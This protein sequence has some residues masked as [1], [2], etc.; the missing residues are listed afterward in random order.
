MNKIIYNDFAANAEKNA[1]IP[2]SGSSSYQS[3]NRLLSEDDRDILNFASFEGVGID[4]LDNSLYF[5]EN[6]DNIGYVSSAISSSSNIFPNNYLVIELSD[7]SYSAPGITFYFFK[8][9]CSHLTVT[10]LNG[11]EALSEKKIYVVPEEADA[12][13][14]IKFYYENN[15]DGFNKIKIKFSMTNLKNQFAKLAGIDL[16]RQREITNFH[17]NIQI[18]SEIDPDCAD[19]PGSTCDFIAEIEDFEPSQAQSFFVY[20]GDRL[21]G[22]YYVD[23][24]IPMGKNRYSFECSD[25]IMKLEKSNCEALPQGAYSV[26]SIAEAI[27]TLSNLNIDR[28]GFEDVAV[29]GFLEENTNRYAAAMLSFATGCFLTGFGAKSLTLKKPVNRRNKIISS[30]KILGRAEYKEKTQYSAVVLKIFFD[31]F[32]TVTS[33]K[34]EKNLNKKATDSIGNNVFEQ[35]SLIADENERFNELIESGFINNEITARIEMQD[36]SLGDI[37]SIETPYNGIK[38]GIIKSMDIILGFNKITATITMIERD[39][40]SRGGEA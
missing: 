5:A 20:G 25:A 39:Y 32:E 13:G 23:E 11:D 7:G 40:A 10:W 12:N 8:D 17:S 30:S 24:V 31:D 38:T 14:L 18:F 37:L 35:F 2:A 33:T 4:L 29:T 22:R 21:F 26:D 16:G 34:T 27:Y 1:T 36:E 9:Y 3:C 28:N 15:V 19:A 6:G